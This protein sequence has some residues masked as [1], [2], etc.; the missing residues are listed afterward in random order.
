MRQTQ[1]REWVSR[2]TKALAC[3]IKQAGYRI[4]L[5]RRNQI[6]IKKQKV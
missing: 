4:T 1:R 2:L 3:R 5:D 6:V